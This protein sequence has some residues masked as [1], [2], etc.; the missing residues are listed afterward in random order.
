MQQ[1]GKE[2]PKQ[3]CSIRDRSYRVLDGGRSAIRS[4]LGARSKRAK[5]VSGPDSST[6]IA[7]M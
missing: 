5:G 3:K 6:C 4:N 7:E 2:R 1:P